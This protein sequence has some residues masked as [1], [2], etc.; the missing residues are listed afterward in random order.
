MKEWYI[1]KKCKFKYKTTW[2][3]FSQVTKKGKEIIEFLDFLSKHP[4][5]GETFSKYIGH[6]SR[7]FVL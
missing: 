7:C 4:E 3:F 2:L 6:R 5:L 1:L